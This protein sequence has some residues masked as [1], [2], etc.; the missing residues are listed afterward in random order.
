M[1]AT[2]RHLALSVW[3][4]SGVLATPGVAAA[5]SIAPIDPNA[6]V[7]APEVVA[8]RALATQQRYE[9]ERQ[10]TLWVEA[11]QVFVARKFDPYTLELEAWDRSLQAASKPRRLAGRSV[12]PAPPPPPPLRIGMPGE[13]KTVVG[14]EAV[15]AIKGV[16]PARR[17]EIHDAQGWTSCGP[18]RQF[19]V[20]HADEDAPV[21]VF[22]KGPYPTQDGVLE[23]MALDHIVDPDIKAALDKAGAAR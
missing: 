21:V 16:A 17:F 18:L 22:V 6:P 4:A 11:D 3:L 8:A 1:G 2:L 14:L 12:P 10:Q 20:F 5:C 15:T 13:G 19:D 7:E 23:A 9:L